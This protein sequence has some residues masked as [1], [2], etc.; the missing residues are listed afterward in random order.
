MISILENHSPNPRQ[1]SSPEVTFISDEIITISRRNVRRDLATILN[2]ET[3]TKAVSEDDSVPPIG[4]SVA[5]SPQDNVERMTS[6][7]LADSSLMAKYEREEK[8]VEGLDFEVEKILDRKVL[9]VPLVFHGDG[10]INCCIY[11]GGCIIF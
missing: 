9:K 6:Q 5:N 7:E 8:D 3:D 4:H 11:R 10:L 1:P 2:S